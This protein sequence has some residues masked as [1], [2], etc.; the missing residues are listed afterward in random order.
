MGDYAI[1]LDTGSV[2]VVIH[3][4]INVFRKTGCTNPQ[5][6]DLPEPWFLLK[7]EAYITID[8]CTVKSLLVKLP[9]RAVPF[10]KHRRELCFTI[11]N[12]VSGVRV[13][14]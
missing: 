13:V 7:I 5:K 8:V 1:L 11:T 9:A 12:H 4:F 6:M 2:Q 14:L 10:I 3:V